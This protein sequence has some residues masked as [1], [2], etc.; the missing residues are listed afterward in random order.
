MNVNEGDYLVAI[1]GQELRAPTNP[2]E[3]LEGTAG[4]TI[5]VMVND[6]PGMDGARE[7]LV[8]P[9]SSEG[10]LRSWAWIAENQRKVDEL[11][12]GRLAYVYLPN[13]GQGGYQYFNRMYFRA[14]GSPGRG[15]R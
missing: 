13:T 2:F 14:A 8:E 12:G 15:H 3:L 5:R 11:S 10:Q 6:R 1:E 4:R 9:I 7:L